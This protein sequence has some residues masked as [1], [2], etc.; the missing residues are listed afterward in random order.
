MGETGFLDLADALSTGSHESEW[1][2]G[3]S[4]AYYAAFHKARR[5]L[6]QSGFAVP[7][8]HPAHAYPCM[9]LSNSGHPD[10]N[11]MGQKLNDLRGARNWADYYFD[12][13]VDSAVAI[14]YVGLALDIIQLIHHLVNEPAILRPVVDAIKIYEGDILH[15]VTWHS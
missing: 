1:R 4:R 12:V 15:E 9:R 2:S 8:G 3:I 13:P 7:R 11:E 5:L 6:R 14:E 10:V